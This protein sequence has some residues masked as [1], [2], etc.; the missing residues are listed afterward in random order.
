MSNNL[1]KRCMNSA[2][3]VTLGEKIFKLIYGMC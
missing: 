1:L 2:V 3:N